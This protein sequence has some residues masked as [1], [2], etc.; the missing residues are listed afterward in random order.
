LVFFFALGVS[1]DADADANADRLARG[2]AAHDAINGGDESRI[3]EALSLLG[4]ELWQR[5]PL[6][7]AYHGSILTLEAS[8]ANRE[9]KLV[10]A[11]KF[12]DDGVNEIDKAVSLDPKS[13]ELRCLRMENSMALVETSPSDRKKEIAEDIAFLRG[14]WADLDGE[15]KAL[16]E[17]D[18]GRLSLAQKRLSEALASWRKA[19]RESPDSEAAARARKLIGRYGS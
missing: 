6:A 15:V 8:K 12:I 17:L 7:L 10:A 2:I 3:A 14:A 16:V 5:P 13:V 18:S 4:P 19:V 1:A 11:L 9:G